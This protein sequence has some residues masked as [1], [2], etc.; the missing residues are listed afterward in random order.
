MTQN[1]DGSSSEPTEG[2]TVDSNNGACSFNL[3]GRGASWAKSALQPMR[4]LI[5]AVHDLITKANDMVLYPNPAPHL[6]PSG[7]RQ[8]C[9]SILRNAKKLQ[10]FH[11]PRAKEARQ[12]RD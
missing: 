1:L 10:D 3:G 7:K 9:S 5:R 6:L 8:M 11:L 2:E 4:I 12:L